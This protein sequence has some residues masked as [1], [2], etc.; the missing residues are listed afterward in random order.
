MYKC[1]A[2]D[3]EG[4]AV[5]KISDYI[6]QYSNLTLLR[7]FTS[8]LSALTDILNR[9]AVDI[10]FLDIDMPEMSG[11]ELAKRVRHKTKKLVFISGHSKFDYEAFEADANGYLLKPYSFPKFQALLD[12]LFDVKDSVIEKND[13]ILVKRRDSSLHVKL[14]IDEIISIEASLHSILIVTLNGQVEVGMS[15]TG[16]K[17]ILSG[18]TQFLQVHRSFII[19]LNH[20]SGIGSN[21]LKMIDNSLVPIGK[22][23]R[24]AVRKKV[25]K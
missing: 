8:P 20:I 12:K 15:L 3:D 21:N 24:D 13:Y 14:K 11:L 1:Y 5:E 17:A 7:S 4:Y 10:I 23:Y 19:S 2:V 25:F 18:H 6:S 9:D 22:S 16:A